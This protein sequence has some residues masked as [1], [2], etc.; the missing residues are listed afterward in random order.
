VAIADG[1]PRPNV[2]QRR[3]LAILSAADAY[4]EV[5]PYGVGTFR[6]MSAQLPAISRQSVAA[7]VSKQWLE[8]FGSTAAPAT[9][10]TEVRKAPPPPLY[11]RIS[12][13]GRE[14]LRRARM[15][16]E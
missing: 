1:D 9:N 14:A 8:P 6:G 15:R 2:N 16:R 7:M 12:S 13:A 5:N 11:Y 10:M 4:L 3:I